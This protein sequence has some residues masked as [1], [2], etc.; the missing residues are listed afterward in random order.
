MEPVLVSF[1]FV[2]L[3]LACGMSI[4]A[5]KLLRDRHER[6]AARAEALHALAFEGVPVRRESAAIPRHDLLDDLD[7]DPDPAPVGVRLDGFDHPADLRLRPE[8]RVRPERRGRSEPRH[9]AD[10]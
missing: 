10:P 6:S 9:A 8:P 4:V 1:A 5:W 3:A 7:L 2:S